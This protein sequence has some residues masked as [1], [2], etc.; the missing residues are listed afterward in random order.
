MTKHSDSMGF[1]KRLA[2]LCLLVAPALLLV[3]EL[4]HPRMQTNASDQY[5]VLQDLAGRQYASHLIFVIS[6]ITFVP[7]LLGL[8]HLT[9]RRPIA[10]Q[11][12]LTL[13]VIG[14]GALAAFAGA[15]LVTW[16]A[17]VAP[18]ADAPAMIAL[19]ERVST[20]PGFLPLFVGSAAFPL[21][22]VVSAFA[23]RRTGEISLWEA[24]LMGVAPLVLLMAEFSGAPTVAVAVPSVA[25]LVVLWSIGLRVLRGSDADWANVLQ[26]AEAS[27]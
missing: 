17:A 3:G 7:A 2:G 12:G 5:H 6:V 16:Q 1:P 10:S 13:G 14:T 20:S 8:M 4:L 21:A 26:T 9:S 24:I 19:L 23:L 27:R 22:F 25:F 11:V 18:E 15:E